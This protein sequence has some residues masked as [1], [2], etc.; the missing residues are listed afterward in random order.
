MVINTN[1]IPEV[2]RPNAYGGDGRLLS[3]VLLT[4]EQWR[5]ELKLCNRLRIEPGSEIGRHAHVD[6]FELYYILSGTGLLDDDGEPRQVNPG[7]LIYTADGAFHSLRNNGV[8]M[9][10]LLAI[11][12]ADNAAPSQQ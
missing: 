6:D 4:E 10:E 11:V 2:I 9:L 8:E 1:I 3:R 12:I 7:D 5:N